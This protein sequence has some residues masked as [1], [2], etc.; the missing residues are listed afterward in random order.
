MA[1]YYY[2]YPFGENADDLVEIPTSAAVDGSISYY[3]GYTDPYEYDL[4]TNPNALP[5][6]RGSF[7]Q[8]MFQATQN[9]QQYQQYGTPNWIT[10]AD[11]LGSP[12]EYPIYARVYYGDNVYENLVADNTATP[13]ADSTWL[14]VSGTTDSIQVGMSIIWNS[15]GAPSGR[16]LFEDGSAVSRT[17]YSTL[18]NVLCPTTTG[19]TADTSDIISSLASTAEYH[20]GMKVEGAGIPAGATVIAIPGGTSVQIS[21]AATATATGVTLRFFIWGAGNGSTTFNIPDKTGNYIAGAGGSGISYA[22]NTYSKVGQ[23]LGA[24]TYE[25]Q[26]SDLP[27]HTH[28]LETDQWAGAKNVVGATPGSTDIGTAESTITAGITGYTSQTD[29]PMIPPSVM[30]KS[31]IRY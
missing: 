21:A 28:D 14:L 23:S 16:Y 10:S 15:L 12:F 26:E 25:I 3:A 8:L 31:F 24:A 22:G 30:I 4:L 6:A 1:T 17:T 11:N 9:I 19:N 2:V 18:F 13:G 5:V 27:D 29:I 7:N 20:I